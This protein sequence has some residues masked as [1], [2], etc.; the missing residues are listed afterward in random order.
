[1]QTS[2]NPH[3]HDD[4]EE[5]QHHFEVLPPS[6]GPNNWVKRLRRLLLRHW[7]P[8][9]LEPPHVD[10]E[11]PKLTAVER[12]AEVF[13]FTALNTEHW[14]S[15]KGYLR[16]WL[17]FNARVFMLLLIPTLLVVPL[18]T[19]TLGQFMTWAALIAATTASIVLF[20]LSA[21]LVVGLISGLVYLSK[22]VFMRQRDPR[23]DH[24]Y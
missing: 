9:P 13:R 15:P 10:P 24:Y 23:R 19:F 22:S 21:L 11:L 8:H 12:S 7:Q 3:W 20:P 14:L 17:R 16:E 1:M 6:P 4:E 5:E 2:P 18:I